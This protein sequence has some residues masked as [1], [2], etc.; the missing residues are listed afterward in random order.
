MPVSVLDEESQIYPLHPSPSAI[1]SPVNGVRARKYSETEFGSMD[2]FLFRFSWTTTTLGAVALLVI[3]CTSLSWHRITAKATDPRGENEFGRK[4][5]GSAS[6]AYTN[7]QAV[8]D[9]HLSSAAV[10]FV[11]V[12]KPKYH[13]TMG[14]NIASVTRNP[15][16][17]SSQCLKRWRT[18]KSRMYWR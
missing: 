2:D 6:D 18:S 16:D 17:I 7:I 9:F 5:N 10:P 14:E 8:P 11:P 3:I 4:H 13:I 15:F 1:T 12:F